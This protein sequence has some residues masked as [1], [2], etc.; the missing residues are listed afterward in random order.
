MS[1]KLAIL[2]VVALVGGYMSM[3]LVSPAPLVPAFLVFLAVALME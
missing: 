1:D 3:E 2:I